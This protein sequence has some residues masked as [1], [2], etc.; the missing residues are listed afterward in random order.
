MVTTVTDGDDG[1]GRSVG[2]ALGKEERKK[3][4]RMDLTKKAQTMGAAQTLGMT[5]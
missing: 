5:Q 4:K 2:W 3:M 1:D